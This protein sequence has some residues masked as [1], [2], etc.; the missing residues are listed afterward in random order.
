M[1][2]LLT[3]C[4]WPLSPRCFWQIAGIA[5]LIATPF[6]LA[7]RATGEQSWELIWGD[8]FDGAPNSPINTGPEGWLFDLGTS[9]GCTGC[10]PQWGTGEVETAT[11]SLENVSLDG[12]GHLRIT[13]LRDSS[14]R[15][16]SG[17]IETRRSDFRA[18]NGG[19]LAVE[20][21]IQQ[22]SV[23]GAQA[24]GYWPAFWMLGEQFRGNYLNWPGIGEIDILESVNGRESVFAALHCGVAPGGPCNE[25]TGLSSGEHACPNCKTGFH[26]YRMELDLSLTPNQIRWYLDGVQHF[27]LSAPGGSLDSATWLNAVDHGFFIILD[28]AI[29]GGFPAAFGGGPTPDTLPGVP[30][31]IDYVRVY[32]SVHRPSPPRNLRILR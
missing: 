10:P 16:T 11:D 7:G 21:A 4:R 25:F 14:G 9:Y 32:R 26:V 23:S 5:A 30:M 17:R 15:W 6:I 29:G 3:E 20:A 12:L 13:P 27:A 18:P 19:V 31:I 22:P 8:E 2:T 1:L 24:S 28:V